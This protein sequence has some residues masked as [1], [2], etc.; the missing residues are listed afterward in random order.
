MKKFLY[1]IM[2]FILLTILTSLTSCAP[3]EPEDGIPWVN[4]LGMAAGNSHYLV[5]IIKQDSATTIAT[6]S[7]YISDG[8]AYVRSYGD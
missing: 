6:G 4:L 8:T 2:A 1:L 3:P 5:A 7:A